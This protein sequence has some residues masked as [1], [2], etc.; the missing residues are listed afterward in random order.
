MA[1]E[2]QVV[3]DG[4]EKADE[5]AKEGAVADGVPMA[6]ARAITIKHQRTEVYASIDMLTDCRNRPQGTPTGWSSVLTLVRV[7][8]V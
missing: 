1:E 4:N 6:A 5:L 2:Q 7:G 3:L 8:H